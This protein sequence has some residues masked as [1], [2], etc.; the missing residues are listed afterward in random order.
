MGEV[1]EV[2]GGGTPRTSDAANFEGGTIPWITPADLSGYREK[3]ISR[4]T[5]NITSKGLSSSAAKLLPSGT[6]LFSSRAPIGYVAIASTAVAT[7]Q[8]FKSFVLRDGL[9]S[10]YVYYYLQRARELAVGLASG[11]T[12]LEISGAKAA[13]IPIPVPPPD[14]QDRI[15]AEIEKQFTRIDAAIGLIQRVKRNLNVWRSALVRTAM[16]GRL[17]PGEAELAHRSGQPFE[18][19]SDLLQ[20]LT[21]RAGTGIEMTRSLFPLPNSPW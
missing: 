21:G 13:Q 14:E 11:T 5:R 10:D 16:A 7:N 19:A 2:V 9:K 15:V 4:G 12:F 6:V 1:A 17:V 20:R 3:F 18:S 8:G